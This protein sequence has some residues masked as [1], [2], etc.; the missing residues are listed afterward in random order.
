MGTRC[1]PIF[2]RVSSF[3]PITSVIESLRLY[4]SCS[5]P[6]SS[7]CSYSS[8]PC[9]MSLIPPSHPLFFPLYPVG[10]V[11][12]SLRAMS[13]VSLFFSFCYVLRSILCSRS[14]M[15]PPDTVYIYKPTDILIDN[16]TKV[17]N[18]MLVH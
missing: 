5:L 9:P 17:Y 6:V 7:P 3:F 14:S 11:F 1:K 18:H 12:S 10:G 15:I 16:Y 2:F 8:S 13:L 4:P